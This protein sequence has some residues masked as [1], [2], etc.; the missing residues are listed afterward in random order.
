MPSGDSSRESGVHDEKDLKKQNTKSL[1]KGIKSLEG[2]IRTH[3]EYLKNPKDHVSNW[4]S[5]DK[6]RQDKLINHW[7]HEISN[8]S[9]SIQNR[10]AELKNRGENN[11]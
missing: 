8:F 2:K 7:K 5:L 6:R 3:E 10:K 4:D 11:D 1:R 9:K